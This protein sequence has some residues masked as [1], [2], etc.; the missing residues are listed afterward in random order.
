MVKKKKNKKTLT[1]ATSPETLHVFYPK[2]VPSPV[3]PAH[4]LQKKE[5]I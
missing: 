2:W 4:N 3:E 1:F 5:I